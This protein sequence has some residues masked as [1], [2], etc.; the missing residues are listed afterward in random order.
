L[1]QLLLL[2]ALLQLFA[3]AAPMY[4]QIVVDDVLVKHDVDVLTLLALGFVLLTIIQVATKALRGWTSLYLGNQ[5]ARS[6][7]VRLVSHLLR[8]PLDYFQTRHAGDIASRLRSLQPVQDFL[9]GGVI[10]ALID[11]AMAVTTLVVLLLYSPLLAGIVIAAFAGYALAR[12]ALF[13]PLRQRSQEAIVAAARL[14]SHLL[15]TI[16]ALQSIKLF[17][18]ETERG[19]SWQDLFV[20]SLNAQARSARLNIGYDTLNGIL[21]GLESVLLVFVG[22]QQVLSGALTIGML[23][24]VVAYRTH[25]ANAM[26]SLI[27]QAIAYL[28]LQ[29]HLERIADIALTDPEPGLQAESSFIAPVRGALAMQALRF[30]WP[31][32]VHTL[33]DGID[34][35]IAAG[36]KLAIVGAS[37]SGKSTL[38]RLLLGL[39]EPTSGRVLCDGVPLRRLGL[40]AYRTGVA[41]LLQD[42]VLLTG[43]IRDNI[44]FFDVQCDP[45]RLEHAARLAHVYD[46]IMQLPLRFD[47]RI[48]DLATS[49]SAGQAQR[50]LLARALY[51]DAAVLLLD[52]GTS[53]LDSA[54]ELAVMRD[55]LAL[56]ITCI[57]ATHRR[58][59]A[60][61]AD[62]VLILGSMGWR[63]R[64]GMR[65]TPVDC[66]QS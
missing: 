46:D 57:F 23:Y 40:R 10:A 49:L 5:L 30:G 29:L 47:S 28:M 17:G 20:A 42:D 6:V 27:N 62:R 9:T 48:G 33:L 7:G 44:S 39:H 21:L 31:G 38:L 15:E 53:H 2:S 14:D 66:A 35:D 1:L 4:M 19:Q 56:P 13:R 52:E 8:L 18:R 50:V 61:Q 11:G 24:A 3:L 22:A 36:E 37:G 34:L 12:F 60:E 45:E 16:R 54:T 55:I 32:E 51:R 65:A 43:T 41:A 59:I 58:D 64:A 63:I 25:F 26:N